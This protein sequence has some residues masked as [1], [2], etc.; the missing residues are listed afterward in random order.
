MQETTVFYHDKDINMLELGCT[1][2][3]LANICLQKSTDANFFPSTEGDENLMR[4]SREQFLGGPS[5][6]F[7]CKVVVD[8]TFVGKSKNISKSNVG[9]DAGQVYPYSMC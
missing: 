4:K 3:N 8:E 7:P 9:I 1:L 6:V 2:P 5:S